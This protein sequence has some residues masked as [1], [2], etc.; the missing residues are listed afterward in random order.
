MMETLRRAKDRFLEC[1]QITARQLAQEF[2]ATREEIL[3]LFRQVRADDEIQRSLSVWGPS[4][5][6][7]ISVLRKYLQD[8]A[9]FVESI[10]RG[11]LG[12]PKILEL[13]P[14]PA[15]PC[16]CI[17]CYNK[18]ESVPS[19]D[20]KYRP[21][22]DTALLTSNE[23]LSIV[24]TLVEQ[25]CDAVYFSGGLE[26]FAS[27][28]MTDVLYR[29]PTKPIVHILTSGVPNTI[30][31]DVL[32]FAIQRAALFRFSIHAANP[33]TY[34]VVQLPNRHDGDVIFDLVL[35]RVKKAVTFRN[36]LRESGKP[37]AEIAVT[38][39][40]VPANYLELE[41]AVRMWTSIGIDRF[42]IGNDALQMNSRVKPFDE[43]QKEELERIFTKI[44]AMADLG[45]WNQ[46][47][48]RPSRANVQTSLAVAQKCFAPIEK[49]VLD[50]YGNLWTC[51]LRA[52]PSLQSSRFHLGLLRNSADVQRL[53]ENRNRN[54]RTNADLPLGFHCSECTEYDYVANVWIDKLVSDLEFGIAINEQPFRM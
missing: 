16:A 46:M 25:G 20:D 33:H 7:S 18:G 43:K 35:S 28:V 6:Y 45:T 10:H 14:S 53:L 42:D 23:I 1:P 21:S 30:S 11:E 12:C 51:C 17:F 37:A 40:P 4:D 15:C 27:S 3:E 13:H 2:G 44:K 24:N 19:G 22:H 47:K 8:F 52:N 54:S 38:F 9:G 29:I 41:D 36:N 48:I 26:P 34:G 39:F 50:P 32:Q 5:G 31:D 49:A